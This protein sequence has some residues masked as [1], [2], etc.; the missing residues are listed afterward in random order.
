MSYDSLKFDLV[1]NHVSFLAELVFSANCPFK[2]KKFF[3][4]IHA[5]EWRIDHTG[6][7]LFRDCLIFLNTIINYSSIIFMGNN[8]FLKRITKNLSKSYSLKN[9]SELFSNVEGIF[10]QCKTRA[11]VRFNV[12]PIL[13][14]Q[15]AQLWSEISLVLEFFFSSRSM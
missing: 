8:D 12:I 6:L 2:F 3:W 14:M 7:I 15:Y 5:I 13:F 10:A 11:N 1:I 9:F 4:N